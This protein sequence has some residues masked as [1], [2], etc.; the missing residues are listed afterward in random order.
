MKASSILL[1]FWSAGILLLA[2]FAVFRIA[3]PWL[4]NL[5]DTGAL[6]SGLLL[7][8]GM[9]TADIFFSLHLGSLL[10][11]AFKENEYEDD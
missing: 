6:L 9:L 2:N 10:R 11:D 7:G 8:A 5:H 3:M 4:F 1:L